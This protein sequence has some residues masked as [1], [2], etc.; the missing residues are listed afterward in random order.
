MYVGSVS[1][2]WRYVY[3]ALFCCEGWNVNVIRFWK[4]SILYQRTY[5]SES[6][7]NF[8]WRAVDIFWDDKICGCT[9][10]SLHFYVGVCVRVAPCQVAIFM[11]QMRG[12][13]GGGDPL[14][15]Y[16]RGAAVWTYAWC[17]LLSL[18]MDLGGGG[19]Q[20]YC[21]ILCNYICGIAL[22]WQSQ[23]KVLPCISR[24]GFVMT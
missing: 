12:E 21:D 1:K 11:W 2:L 20:K 8:D 23:S 16:L 9:E 3:K 5:F 18:Q 19:L 15:T 14:K 24:Y 7:T 13:G 10:L 22:C 6:I 17:T 4:Y